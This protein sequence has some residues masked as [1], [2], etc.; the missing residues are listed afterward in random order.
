MPSTLV[1][2]NKDPNKMLRGSGKYY[3]RGA[4]KP[5]SQFELHKGAYFSKFSEHRDM[6]IKA[7]GWRVDKIGLNT[8]SKRSA[9]AQA[10]DGKKI[11]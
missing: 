8:K 7:K 6:M 5:K 1:F 11:R 3:K 2:F 4:F 10:G 9:I